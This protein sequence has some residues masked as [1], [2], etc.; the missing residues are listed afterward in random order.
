MLRKT[1]GR[2]L[3]PIIGIGILIWDYWDH[4]ETKKVNKPILRQAIADYF[5]E[6]KGSLLYDNDSGIMSVIHNIETGIVRGLDRNI[7]PAAGP[8]EPSFQDSII[9]PADDDPL[10]D[11]NLK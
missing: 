9:K 4:S 2:L 6:M 5:R 11:P 7:M 8:A 1:G 3:G 10:L